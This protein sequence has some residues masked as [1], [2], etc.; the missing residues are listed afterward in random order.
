M[1]LIESR[2]I[3]LT[4]ALTVVFQFFEE[5]EP[6][7]LSW[8]GEHQDRIVWQLE[9]GDLVRFLVSAHIE[10]EGLAIGKPDHLGDCIYKSFN[11]FLQ[12]GDC[13]EDMTMEALENARTW[14]SRLLSE[15]TGETL[16]IDRE[17]IR[18]ALTRP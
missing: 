10:F 4:G 13:A 15:L 16:D 9:N 17:A 11:D 5:E 1:N 6:L 2:K 8:S 18:K 14:T 12:P 7:D 3:A